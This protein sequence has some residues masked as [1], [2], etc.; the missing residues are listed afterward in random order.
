MASL[1]RYLNDSAIYT[2]RAYSLKFDLQ[3]GTIAWEGPDGQ[4]TEGLKS[5]SGLSLQSKGRVKEGQAVVLFGPMGLQ[6]NIEIYLRDGDNGITVI[7]NP[8]SGRAKI[9]TGE[10]SDEG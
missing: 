2:K 10:R 3:E 1:L 8:A 9:V 4:K 7:F 6:E 5:I